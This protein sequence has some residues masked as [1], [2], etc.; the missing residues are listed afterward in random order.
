MTAVTATDPATA[1]PL[2]TALANGTPLREVRLDIT[3]ATPS[4]HGQSTFVIRPGVIDADALELFGF[5]E[6]MFLAAAVAERIGCGFALIERYHASD[7]WKPTHVAAHLP[8]GLLLDIDGHR[9]LDHVLADV[10]A[11]GPWPLRHRMVHTWPEV[12]PERG[13][14]WRDTLTPLV[15][16]MIDVFADVLV[17]AAS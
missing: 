11:I 15:A 10:R 7:G 12:L 8:D 6:C 16:E 5:A 13:Q 1:Y 4:F 9:T 3:L 17:E 14:S 2:L